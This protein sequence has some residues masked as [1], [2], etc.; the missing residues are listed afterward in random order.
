[1]N[2]E[3]PLKKEQGPRIFMPYRI[4]T[5]PS[6]LFLPQLLG[7]RRVLCEQF[8]GTLPARRMKSQQDSR[9]RIT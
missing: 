9:T 3:L 7:A 1:M 6:S 8:K 2:T 5:T 4:M